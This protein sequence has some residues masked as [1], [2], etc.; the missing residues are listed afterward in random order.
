MKSFIKIKSLS[1]LGMAICLIP[2]SCC[3]RAETPEITLAVLDP[4]HFHAALV[5]QEKMEGISDAVYVYAPEGEGVKQYLERIESYNNREASPTS[6]K[7]EIYIGENY[8]EE[9]L[10]QKR[11]NV[12]ILAGDNKKKTEYILESVKAGYNVLSD[13]PMAICEED[14]ELLSQ[15]Y[16]TAASKGLVIYELMTERYDILNIVEKR[17]IADTS[18]FGTLMPG[19]K[20]NPA[21]TLESVHHFYKEISGKPLVRPA[22]YYDVSRQGE[23]IADV[24]THLIDLIQWQCFPEQGIEYGR[25]IELLEASRYPTRISIEQFARSTNESHFPDYLSS[26]TKEGFIEV[27]AN[28]GIDFKIKGI[29]SRLSVRWDYEAPQGE[30]DTYYSIKRGSKADLKIVQNSLTGFKR[31]LYICNS[32]GGGRQDFEKKLADMVE[33]LRAEYPF[34]SIENEG[35]GIYMIKMPVE[36]RLG[37]TEHFSRVASAFFGYVRQGDLP[38]WEKENVLSKYRLT[39]QA[40][41][42][43]S[44]Q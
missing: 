19:T 27:M 3:R 30:G 10:S 14:F 35:E 12:V 44:A 8:L 34:I 38:A 39:T 43:A 16:E 24:T 36:N 32:S 9:M 41:K 22:W 1:L 23:G 21:V 42:L 37:H 17:I 5:Q 26:V 15:A 28:G 2:V 33:S 40:V 11:G 25:D 29:H 20:E 31:Q 7:E 4:G 18:L 6:W 13:K